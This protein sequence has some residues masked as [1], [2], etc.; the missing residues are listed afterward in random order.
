MNLIIFVFV[1]LLGMAIGSFLNVCIYRLPRRESI[2][3]PNSYCPQCKTRIKPYHNIPIFSYLL[4]GGRCRYCQSKI[5]WHYFVVELVTPL[6]F[7]AVFRFYGLSLVSLKYFIF[8]SA[9]IIIF[10]I[11]AFHQIIPDK[12]SLPLIALGFFFT[13]LPQHD[14]GILSSLLGA[15]FGFV[16]FLAIALIFEKFTH[17]EAL[18]GGDIKLIAAI[19]SFTGILGTIFTIIIASFIA[20]IFLLITKHDRTKYFSYGSFLVVGAI[21]YILFFQSLFGFYLNLF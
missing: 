2:I 6:L 1:F 20:F 17:K 21:F 7:V 3:F 16:V 18:G 11:D 8:M 12:L 15:G 19:G 13:L 10:F 14:V 4:L 9:G 5:H